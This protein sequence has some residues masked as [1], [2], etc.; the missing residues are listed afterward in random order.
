MF[1]RERLPG[2]K[3]RVQCVHPR[4]HDGGTGR[5]AGWQQ[6]MRAQPS[7]SVGR[8]AKTGVRPRRVHEP[9]AAIWSKGLGGHSLPTPCRPCCSHLPQIL[10]GLCNEVVLV[11]L[12]RGN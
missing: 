5:L 9:Q 8:I 11:R 12:Q 10:S 7:K 1:V 2:C 4:L 6:L 3:S